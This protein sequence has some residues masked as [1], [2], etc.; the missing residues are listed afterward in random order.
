MPGSQPSTPPQ[1]TPDLPQAAPT[2]A[3]PPVHLRA[4]RTATG[5]TPHSLGTGARTGGAQHGELTFVG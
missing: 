5:R 4:L 1:Q 3:A 2:A